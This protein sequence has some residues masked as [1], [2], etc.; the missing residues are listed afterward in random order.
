MEYMLNEV[1][2]ARKVIQTTAAHGARSPF[3]LLCLDEGKAS[4]LS[5]FSRL[6]PSETLL[7]F[8]IPDIS[9]QPFYLPIFF[10]R[11]ISSGFGI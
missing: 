4:I 11:G 1:T 9:S 10:C 5:Y 2:P 7:L 8:A 6:S 3:E